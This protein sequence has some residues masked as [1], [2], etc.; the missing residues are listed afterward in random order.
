[1]HR[2]D[3]LYG[4]MSTPFLDLS[5]FSD[6]LAE[7]LRRLRRRPK[8]RRSESVFWFAVGMIIGIEMPGAFL[9]PFLVFTSQPEAWFSFHVLTFA[10]FASGLACGW[11]GMR[12]LPGLLR[13]RRREADW[14]INARQVNLS[15]R[16]DDPW[17]ASAP[18]DNGELRF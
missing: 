15:A 8:L 6:G 12:F 10:T 9:L 14:K 3:Q 4:R 11:L 13:I 16:V 5:Y 18:I 17:I 2:R 1:M 7:L